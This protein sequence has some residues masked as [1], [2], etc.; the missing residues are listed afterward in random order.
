MSHFTVLIAVDR[1]ADTDG[2]IAAKLAPYD[3]G[4]DVAPR[5]EPM[6]DEDVRRMAEH[7]KVDATPEALLPHMKDWHGRDGMIRDGKL[8]GVTQYNPDSKWDWYKVGGR[9]DGDIRHNRQPAENVDYRP[10][11]FIDR[12]GFWHQRGR[13]GWWGIVTGEQD[14]DAWA[15]QVKALIADSAGHDLVLVD[16]HI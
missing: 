15:E 11:A 14:A 13:M 5:A 1:A 10:F 6:S 12:H 16:C 9:W 2:A 8:C 3:E 7:Y 4:R